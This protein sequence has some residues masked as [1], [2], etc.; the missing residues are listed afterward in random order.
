MRNK[1]NRTA[2]DVIDNAPRMKSSGLPNVDDNGNGKPAD[3]KPESKTQGLYRIIYMV[4]APEN[5]SGRGVIQAD[6]PNR[7]EYRRVRRQLSR[8]AGMI[9]FYNAFGEPQL[10]HAASPNMVSI[11]VEKYEVKPA[12]RGEAPSIILPTQDS[13]SR[14]H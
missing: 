13:I 8:K 3:G 9:K 5:P 6:I 2:K 7:K 14:I 12:K 11:T 4:Y 10:M 1:F